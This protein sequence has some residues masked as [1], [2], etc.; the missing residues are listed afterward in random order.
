MAPKS[1]SKVKV[2]EDDVEKG[3]AVAAVAQSNDVMSREEL[4]CKL[5]C[6]L[7]GLILVGFLTMDAVARID[8]MMD[9]QFQEIKSE[10]HANSK[11]RAIVG[12]NG[13]VT[14]VYVTQL[15]CYKDDVTRALPHMLAP[16]AT[17]HE[18]LKLTLQSGNTIFSLQWYE[19]QCWAGTDPTR[20]TM[21][22]QSTAC[23]LNANGERVGS[24]YT[25]ALHMIV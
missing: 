14:T 17:F 24:A 15:G 1:K 12:D 6:I 20:A 4:S 25:N 22:G 9:K 11:L 3:V 8:G 5:L 7:L 21:Y 18:C 13:T 23:S 2:D 16:T 10:L 19:S